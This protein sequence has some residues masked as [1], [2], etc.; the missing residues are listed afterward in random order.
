MTAFL[1]PNKMITP[2]RHMLRS[3]RRERK[4]R[5]KKEIIFLIRS[6]WSTYVDIRSRANTTR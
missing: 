1:K 6:L 5:N 3:Y 4:E 2:L